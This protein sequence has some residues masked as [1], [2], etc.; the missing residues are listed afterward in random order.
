[1]RG[2]E[3]IAINEDRR[4][5]ANPYQM[6]YGTQGT[7]PFLI[8]SGIWNSI[9]RRKNNGQFPVVIPA[10]PS[11]IAKWAFAGGHWDLKI[12]PIQSGIY[13]HCARVGYAQI[14]ST[15]IWIHISRNQVQPVDSGNIV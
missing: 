5:T 7:S 6:H 15:R 10:R 4:A 2:A 12:H 9:Q 8:V 1:M 13:R 11:S 14:P 3:R